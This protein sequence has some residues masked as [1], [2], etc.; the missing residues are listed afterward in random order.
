MIE[1]FIKPDTT[2][3]LASAEDVEVVDSMVAIML[4]FFRMCRGDY[5]NIAVI[6]QNDDKDDIDSN[7]DITMITIMKIILTVIIIII[8]ILN[9]NINNG[10]ANNNENNNN[11]NNN[12]NNNRILN[13]IVPSSQ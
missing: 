8:M 3:L 1:V 6:L 13:V 4:S 7:N 12:N 5:Q 10:N 11:E 2:L 9:Y